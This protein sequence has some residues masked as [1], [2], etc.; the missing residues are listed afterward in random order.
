[1]TGLTA[2]YITPFALALKANNVHIGL[3][4][5]VPALC[6]SAAQFKAADFVDFARGRKRIILLFVLAHLLMLLPLAA[7]PFLPVVNKIPLFILC[8][9]LFTAFNAVSGPAWASLMA[10]YVPSRSRGKYF[11]WRSKVFGVVTVAS[12][13]FAGYLLYLFKGNI[14]AGFSLI[15]GLAF[16]C[17]SVSWYCLAKMYEPP[18]RMKPDAYFSFWDFI[19]RVRESNFAKFVLFVASLNFCVN[20]AAPFFAVFMVRDLRF[21]YAWYTILVVTVTAV[22]T[23]T[24]DRWGRHADRVGNVKIIQSNAFI[25]ASL[26][27][28]WLLWHNP[29]YL[30]L[31]QGLSGFAW[32]GFNLCATNFVYDAARPEKRTRCIGYFNACNGVATFCGAL[33]GG[34]LVTRLPPLMGYKIQS[35]FVFSSFMRFAA[36]ALLARRIRE[37]RPSEKI[38]S[39]NLFYSVIG[40]RPAFG[41]TGEARRVTARTEE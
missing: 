14:L 27:L 39:R 31:I 18:F 35:L 1:M 13:F 23:F 34:F 41:V 6:A 25:I 8:V 19:R 5:A 9:T 29:L 3:L 32:S 22:T 40:F 28:W 24:I 15:F 12:A 7:L 11:G 2:D 26:P 16:V 37:V 38:S 17:R 33:I 20:L 36:V 21:S 30:L 4:S 10:D